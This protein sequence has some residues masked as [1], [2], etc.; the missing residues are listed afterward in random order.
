MGAGG[1]SPLPEC[2]RSTKPNRSRTCSHFE[3][4]AFANWSG[5]R[6]PTEFEWER[7]AAESSDR[8]QLCRDRALSAR[9]GR[10]PRLTER[11]TQMYGD[12]WEWTRSAYL[13]YPGYRAAPGALGEYNG[14]FMCNQM[15]LRGGS[16]ATSQNHIRADLSQ[17]L[18]TRKTLAIHRHPAGARPGMSDARQRYC[19]SRSRAGDFRFSR[20]GGSRPFQ[21]AAHL[22]SKF[23]YDERGSDL[24]LQIC[25]L[26]EY[27]VTRTETEI[28]AP[29]RGRD[30]RVDRRKCGAGWV[31]H[32]SRRE[33]ADA[34]RSS[35]E[36]DRLSCRSTSRSSV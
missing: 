18:P 14:K 28:S 25:E 7:A 11:C 3:A 36:P 13:P 22:P 9:S 24:F 15:V 8:R 35:G 10:R 1:I 5:A 6:L 27:Y 31:R 4:D 32:R 17:F 34:A 23:F 19:T 21:L 29:A 2:A 12:V 20:P 33:N 26:P 30:C 16:C